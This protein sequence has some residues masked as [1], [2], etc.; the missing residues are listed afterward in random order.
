MGVRQRGTLVPWGRVLSAFART[1]RAVLP[2]AARLSQKL[3]LRENP[4]DTADVRQGIIEAV[5]L[6]FCPSGY[7]GRA[8][9]GR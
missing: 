1:V 6:G 8:Q 5:P 2:S 4:D 9:H 3:R 7:T